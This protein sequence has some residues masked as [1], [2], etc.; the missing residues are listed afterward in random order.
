MSRPA[1]FASSYRLTART[2]LL[3]RDVRE[4]R[5]ESMDK[6]LR[7][8]YRAELRRLD[9]LGVPQASPP[10]PLK[11]KGLAGFLA[12]PR[13]HGVIYDGRCSDYD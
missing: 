6:V 2:V 9:R 1:T 7:R 4:R 11:R 5:G 13:A 12:G 8:L 10:K 3:G